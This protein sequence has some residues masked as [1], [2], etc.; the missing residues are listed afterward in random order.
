[1]NVILIYLFHFRLKQNLFIIENNYQ[2]KEMPL[3]Y[4]STSYFV[5]FLWYVLL[6]CQHLHLNIDIMYFQDLR[7]H[8]V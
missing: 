2:L 3:C 5:V 4:R 6:N 8:F 1:M 7:H